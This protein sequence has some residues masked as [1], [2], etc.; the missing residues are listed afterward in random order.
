MRAPVRRAGCGRP[1]DLS[2][3]GREGQGRRRGV[4]YDLAHRHRTDPGREPR[5][6]HHLA[7]QG[8][9]LL[10]RGERA[11]R[12]AAAFRRRHRPAD[13]HLQ[14]AR[15]E[16]P[17]KADVA[18]R[19]AGAAEP[20]ALPGDEAAADGGEREAVRARLPGGRVQGTRRRQ[21]RVG[22]PELGAG[23]AAHPVGPVRPAA[24]PRPDPALPPGDGHQALER[25][26]GEPVRV[27]GRTPRG[28]SQRRRC[29]PRGAHPE[30]GLAGVREGG[31]AEKSETSACERGLPG[32]AQRRAEDNRAGG[33]ARTWPDGALRD[34]QPGR[35][36]RGPEGLRRRGVRLPAARRRK[37]TELSSEDRLVFTRAKA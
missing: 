25:A 27:L 2:A 9:R 12:D 29:G 33:E 34:P 32:G 37:A 10:A 36:R 8:P 14:D 17:A 13:E 18:E 20:R 5:A 22:G 26:R 28:R 6:H 1:G 23:A 31:T 21:P 19:L 4:W 24:A 11:R 35:G 15:S 30:P 7:R 16:R 3:W